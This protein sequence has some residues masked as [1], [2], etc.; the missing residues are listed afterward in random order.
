MRDRVLLDSNLI[1]DYLLGRQQVNP[2]WEALPLYLIQ[3]QIPFCLAAHQIA[4]IEYVF[5][6]EAKRLG[7]WEKPQAKQLWLCFFNKATIL[8]TPAKFDR[9]HPLAKRDIE[10]YQIHLAAESAEGLIITRDLEFARL[11]G[12]CLTP[13]AFLFATKTKTSTSVPF[14]DLKTSHFEFH[15]ELEVTFDRTLNSGWFILGNE[16]SQFEQEFAEYCESQYC[17]GVGNGLEA[18][19]L[20]LRGYGI[21]AGDEVIVPTHT[22]IATWLAV[23]Q[24][25]ATPVPV[26]P[27]EH[28]YNL[29]PALIESAIT[30]KTKAIMVVHLYGQPADLDAIN[31]VAKKYHLKV[32][33]DAAQA[34]GARYKSRRV[35]SLG[36][37]AGFSF[38]PAKNLGAFGDGGA[39]V[40]NDS[41]LANTVKLLRNYG[42]QVKYSNIRLYM[43]D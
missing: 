23:S 21:G 16:V 17:I 30:P 27:D 6:R 39:I 28:T 41:K 10:D 8:K 7:L 37:A 31:A 14:Y 20:I 40:T 2:F 33:E 11:S 18:L 1:L 38:Y 32:I 24:V 22:F 12:R 34:H 4:S 35:G 3:H 19:A 36:D 26:E 13:E 42:S 25:G 43:Y 29:N 9:E 5:I 15:S